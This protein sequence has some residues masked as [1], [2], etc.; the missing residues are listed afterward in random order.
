MIDKFEADTAIRGLFG[1]MNPPHIEAL[2][3]F[4]MQVQADAAQPD[5][6]IKGICDA[7]RAADNKSVDEA[8]Y[9]FD[10][11]DCITIIETFASSAGLLQNDSTALADVDELVPAVAERTDEVD[12]KAVDA[13]LNEVGGNV[14]AALNAQPVHD[15]SPELDQISIGKEVK[16]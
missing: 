4:V 3:A 6:L 9:M 5:A 10:S 7:I 14:D 8:D 2:V 15:C 11:D 1:T 16:P 13:G 12:A